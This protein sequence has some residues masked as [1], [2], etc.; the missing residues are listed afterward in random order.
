MSLG[1]LKNIANCTKPHDF[2]EFMQRWSHVLHK[3]KVLSDIFLS[4]I[5]SL[6]DEFNSEAFDSFIED[7]EDLI[8][9]FDM[10]E[11]EIKDHPIPTDK[12]KRGHTTNVKTRVEADPSEL[13]SLILA[14]AR[15]AEIQLAYVKYIYISCGRNKSEAADL[16]N[17]SRR[18]VRQYIPY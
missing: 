17:I 1:F 15:L 4:R 18:T 13:I 7:Y 9:S 14:K 12:G 8:H 2:R 6:R 10:K 11:M 16:L 3:D 5:K